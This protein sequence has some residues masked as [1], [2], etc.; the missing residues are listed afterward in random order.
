MFHIGKGTN[1]TNVLWA[2]C[3]LAQRVEFLRDNPHRTDL[4]INAPY[5]EV[6]PPQA[7]PPKLPK[8]EPKPD[9]QR[10]RPAVKPK[11]WTPHL[12]LTLPKEKD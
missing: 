12:E 1:G 5:L 4:D 6:V 3:T 2:R 10:P 7:T 8:A 11:V 9:Q